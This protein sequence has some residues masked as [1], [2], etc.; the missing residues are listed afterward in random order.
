[1]LKLTRNKKTFK[2]IFQGI[3][4]MIIM[5]ISG[6]SS[7]NNNDDSTDYSLNVSTDKNWVSAENSVITLTVKTESSATW[8]VK[9][10]GEDNTWVTINP[11]NGVGNSVVKV[12]LTEN[13]DRQERFLKLV[14]SNT[15]E[16]KAVFITQAGS[17]NTV[18]DISKMGWMELPEK[19]TI[20]NTILI[21]HS[22]P[23]NDLIRNYSMLY[24]TINK[25][26]YW[27]AY[28]MHPYYLGNVSRT[29]DW[30][31]DPSINT[32][33]QAQLFKGFGTKNIDRGHQI[34][35]ADRTKNKDINATT[36][37]FTNMTP[38][39]S[40]LNQGIWADLEARV[41]VW[42]K[43]C[44]TLYVVTGAMIQTASNSQI[45]YL[46]DNVGASVA[47]PKYY[48]KALAKKIGDTYYTI[49]YKMNNENPTYSSYKSYKL[50]VSELEKETGFNFFP[51]LTSGDKNKIVEDQWL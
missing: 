44:D 27:V 38:Q 29:D 46:K 33:L 2:N 49:A 28:P 10:D 3:L 6:C 35:S 37:Y 47:K 1:M 41:R 32:S 20:S 25:V 22:V 21:G 19:R 51:K 48:Y 36:F 42:T 9:V 15:S 43:Q 8:T 34:A 11:D 14:I 13:T 17:K 24:D 39:N 31:Y 50:T 16:Q 5:I 4:F 45:E 30:Q 7:D 18:I 40:Y 23:D 12:N 26:A